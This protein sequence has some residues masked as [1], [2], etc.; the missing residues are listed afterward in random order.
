MR[1]IN[2]NR[3]TKIN[4]TQ[5]ELTDELGNTYACKLWLEKKVNEWQI[6]LPANNSSGRQYIRVK[7]FNEKNVDG[8]YEFET[9]ESESRVLNVSK[10]KSVMTDIEKARLNVLEGEIEMIKSACIERLKSNSAEMRLQ[11]E[12]EKYEREKA[13]LEAELAKLRGLK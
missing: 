4:D 12:I 9:K 5:Y 13:K 2:M 7:V 10:W 11:R 6:K 3:I 8:V 1:G